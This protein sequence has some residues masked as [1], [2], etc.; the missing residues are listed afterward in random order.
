MIVIET[1]HEIAAS[2]G[3]GKSMTHHNGITRG[4][5][6]GEY[7]SLFFI[8]LSCTFMNREKAQLVFF[9]SHCTLIQTVQI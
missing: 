3:H 2:D 9:N 5:D 6:N 1:E 7:S 4:F 8:H